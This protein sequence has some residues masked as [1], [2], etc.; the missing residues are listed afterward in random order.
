ML[1]GVV[2][3]VAVPIGLAVHT[4]GRARSEKNVA[5]LDK[6]IDEALNDHAATHERLAR[7]ETIVQ[8]HEAEISSLRKRWHEF[9]DGTMK[10]AWNLFDEWREEMH[11]KFR[12]IDKDE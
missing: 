8:Q 10:D 12:R 3:A 5:R 9:R 11:K 7:L 6:H 1:V 2:A 4:A